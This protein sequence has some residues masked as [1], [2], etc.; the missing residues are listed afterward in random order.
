MKRILSGELSVV[1][2]QLSIVNY[3][4]FLTFALMIKISLIGSGNVARHLL[5]A[6]AENPSVEI[7]QVYARS[8]EKAALFADYDK[9]T[10]DLQ[11][12]AEADLYL[13]CV[14]DK[15]I[16]EISA[17]LPFKNRLVAHTSGSVPLDALDEDNRKAVFYPLQTFSKS[18]EVDFSGVP[19]CLETQFPTDYKILETAARAISEK[20]YAINSQQRQ[21]LHVS[22]VFANNFVNRLYGIAHEICSA[23]QVPFDILKPLIAETAEKVQTLSPLEA[24]TGPAKRKD[25]V[26]IQAHLAFLSDPK[27]QDIYKILT[28]SIQD[29]QEL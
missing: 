7:V 10:D 3:P 22:A 24:Q 27:Q 1:N 28:Q 12:L 19:I 17:K 13:I 20:P 2:C 21:A 9:I 25:S 5:T 15:A 18:K 23:H 26:T 4:L 8:K 16:A 14:S 6:F 29:A 11:E